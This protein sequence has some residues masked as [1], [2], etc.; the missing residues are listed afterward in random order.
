VALYKKEKELRSMSAYE[1]RIIHMELKERSD[2]KTESIGQDPD[3]RIIIKP[4]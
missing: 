2:V 4:I 3:R 1:R